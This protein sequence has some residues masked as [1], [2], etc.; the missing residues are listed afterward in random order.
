M[1][2]AEKLIRETAGRIAL[3]QHLPE[4]TY[5]LQFHAGFTFKDATALVAY[6][7]DLGI[8]H[9][10]ASPYLQARPGSLHGY[11]I[12]DHRVLNP[13]IGNQEDY[14]AWV[15]EL[16]AHGMGQILDMVPNHM[17]IFGN[18]NVWWNDVLENGPSSPYSGYFDIAWEDTQCSELHHR[19]LLP[20]LGDPYGKVL[21]AQ[22]IRLVYDCGAFA[23]DYF[24]RRF[25]VA[26]RSY[27]MILGQN[28]ENLEKVLG[29]DTP[30]IQE[31]KSIL[32]AIGHLPGRHETNP[33]KIAERQRE[34][35]VVKRRLATLTEQSLP[36]HDSIEKTVVLFN[37]KVGDRH[38]FDLLDTLL[39]DQAYRLSYW[40]VA[41]DEINYRRFFDI[42]ELAALSMEK[43]EVF[44]ITHELVL[45][46]LSQNKVD[47]LR[48]D[49]VDGLYDPVQYLHGYS[50]TICSRVPGKFSIR[51]PRN[52]IGTGRRS[53]DPYWKKLQRG[54]YLM[55]K[56][57]MSWWKRFS[58]Q[59]RICQGAGQ[60]TAPAATTFW[61][62]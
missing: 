47:G 48:I 12:T 46:L 10:Y 53:K 26:P 34:K 2:R 51:M 61:V 8:T 58:A 39:D 17:G 60:P 42:N 44:I 18:V 56:R 16:H 22:Q 4:A 35:E 37:G 13:D 40:R 23:I 27:A 54:H 49:H 1:N 7:H 5:R 28:I 21:E 52:A 11:D 41:A 9:C 6:L 38:S 31:Y 20:V 15:D 45:R 50:S 32:T 62:W 29:P 57:S 43:R 59:L 36:V 19:V 33:E 30:E 14:D 3:R 55:Q 24:D 25:P